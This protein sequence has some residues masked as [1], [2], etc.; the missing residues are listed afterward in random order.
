LFDLT[1]IG[2]FCIDRIQND[3]DKT[4]DIFLGGTAAYCALAA[5]RMGKKVAIVSPVGP[6]LSENLLKIINED[7][8]TFFRI[9]TS[10]SQTSFHHTTKKN[11][12]RKLILLN[13]G[14]VIKDFE[15]PS[16]CLDSKAVLIGSVM[17]EVDISVLEKISKKNIPMGLEIQGYVRDVDKNNEVFHRVWPEME[18]YLKHVTFLKGSINEILA[19]T[20][21]EES[22]ILNQIIKNVSDMGPEIILV[23]K[24]LQGSIIYRKN[25]SI[26]IPATKSKCVDRTGA[27]DTFFSAFMIKYLESNDIFE[28]GYFA[29]AAASYV[30]EGLGASNFGTNEEILNRMKT[31]LDYNK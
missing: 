27:G 21:I 2:N 17:S 29:S 25:I 3:I 12:E 18:E 7:N 16:E 31:K 9:N 14:H 10:T 1:V 4:E 11:N 5:S 28:A 22:K 6:D 26:K 19:A 15:I 23:T 30:V 13:K 24:G 8:I 20:G